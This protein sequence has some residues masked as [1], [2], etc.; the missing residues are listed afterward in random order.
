VLMS[1]VLVDLFDSGTLRNSLLIRMGK[2]LVAGQ[3]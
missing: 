2:S 3:V 1:S